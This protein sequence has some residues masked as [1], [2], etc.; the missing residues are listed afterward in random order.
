MRYLRM[1][2]NAVAAGGLGAAYLTLIFLQLNPGLS[3][4]PWSLAPLV[5]ML[6][7][8]YGVLL[9]VIFYVLILLRQLLASDLSPGWLSLRIL[10]WLSAAAATG[11]AALMWLNLR[12]FDVALEPETVRRMVAGA[13][14]LLV[15]ALLFLAIAL[16]HYSFGRRGSRVGAALFVLTVL[17]SLSLP[18][19]ARGRGEPPLLGAR[20]FEVSGSAPAEGA[21]PRVIMLLLDGASLDFITPAAAEGR[22]PNF[23]KILD[24]GAAMHLATLRP[25]Q[26][27][28]VWTAV[29]TGKLP[30]KSGVRSAATFLVRPDSE[31][32]ELLPDFCFAQ[33][34][35]RFG[36][37]VEEPRTSASVRARPLWEIL[38]GLG[39]T[40]GV[41]GWPLT[42][43]VQPVR[44]FLVGDQ[45]HRVIYSPSD[46]DGGPLLYPPDLL[47]AAR[48]AAED[49]S[50]VD[51]AML[52]A[53]SP[54]G[55]QPG[56]YLASTATPVAVDR[57]YEGVE[58]ELQ[59]RVHAQVT[60][61]RYQSLDAAGH[62]FLR[63][64]VPRVFGDVSDEE[65]HRYGRV[66]ELH[67]TFIDAAVGRGLAA[68]GPD[69]LLLVVSGF[70]M[71]PLSLSKRILERLAGNRELSGTHER[72]PDGFLLAYGR[73]VRPGKL[74]RASIVDVAPTALY[75]LGLPVGRDMDGYART[76]LFQRAFT[77]ERPITFI[78]TY[79]R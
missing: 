11:G 21:A 74:P 65:R 15:C 27:G 51:P 33:A 53:V 34:L 22:L 12:G 52:P 67:Y 61:L 31:P 32:I 76:D 46:A 28:P 41:A 73:A 50:A 38:S 78:P 16:V 35:V 63:Y 69:D 17:A 23:G 37:L 57:L 54:A 49:S 45:F 6:A 58:A 40:V 59:S 29:A 71:E 20:R 68:L 42:H 3:L 9:A 19:A 25:T 60:A 77:A 66:L 72:A 24:R 62:F 14:A 47:A 44:G 79:D 1:L 75:F 18:L 56:E 55:S 13:A 64:A 5:T 39:I 8:T 36:W 43:P 10:V 7:L 30:P 2:T 48:T 70:G 26:P 4:G